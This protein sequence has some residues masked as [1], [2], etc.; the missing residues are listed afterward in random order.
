[1]KGNANL[2]FIEPDQ[3]SRPNWIDKMGEA[4]SARMDRMGRPFAIDI[5]FGTVIYFSNFKGWLIPQGILRG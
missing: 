4:A 2:I 3:L 1:L 5:V